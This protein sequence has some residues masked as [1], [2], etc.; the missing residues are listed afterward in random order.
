MLGLLSRTTEGDEVSIQAEILEA[1]SELNV[2]LINAGCKITNYI[3]GRKG[4]QTEQKRNDTKYRAAM[5]EI[6]FKKWVAS[7]TYNKG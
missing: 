5:A 3:D 4:R 2:K 1:V 7:N 6:E